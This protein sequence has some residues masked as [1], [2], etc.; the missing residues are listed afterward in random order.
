MDT[1]TQARAADTRTLLRPAADT[2]TAEKS[3]T[4]TVGQA[5]ATERA[6]LWLRAGGILGKE[7]PTPQT[8]HSFGP[9]ETTSFTDPTLA[10][11][12]ASSCAATTPC[13]LSPQLE[14]PR[15]TTPRN[16]SRIK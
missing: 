16:S 11:I 13:R 10:P 6:A 5:G 1:V 9:E 14:R 3:A 12:M 7:G 2:R 8:T 4:G 15:A